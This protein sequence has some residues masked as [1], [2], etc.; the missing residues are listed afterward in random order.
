MDP[1]GDQRAG[2]RRLLGRSL[3]VAAIGVGTV[4]LTGCPLI[5]CANL[6]APP[7]GNGG[8]G[9]SFHSVE[10]RAGMPE[11]AAT[12]RVALAVLR[13]Q[14]AR[15]ALAAWRARVAAQRVPPRLS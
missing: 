10:G 2:R 1:N 3:L 15:R 5:S 9:G 6:M 14:V 4:N 12:H 11:P 13:V 7:S 8:H